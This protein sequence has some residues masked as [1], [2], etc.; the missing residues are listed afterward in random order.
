M[1]FSIHL[2][3][4][5]YFERVSAHGHIGKAAL[6]LGV[7]SGAVSK[8]ISQLEE[9][10]GVK[11]IKKKGTG[12]QITQEG[13]KLAREVS[14]PLSQIDDAVSKIM[15]NQ[16]KR[17]LSLTTVPSL[18]S[19]WLIPNLKSIEDELGHEINIVTSRKLADFSQ[20]DIDIAI[21][22][23]EGTWADCEAIKLFPSQEIC[24]VGACLYNDYQE[25]DIIDPWKEHPILMR[26]KWENW[27]L[28]ASEY[29]IKDGLRKKVILDDFLVIREALIN[30]RGFALLP[31][32]LVKD[33][34][35]SGQL[36]RVRVGEI[37]VPQSY[38]LVFSK[39]K[40]RSAKINKLIEIL[41][42]KASSNCLL[43]GG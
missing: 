2:K 39:N 19:R 4:L 8:M 15:Q 35:L 42:S 27:D 22:Y 12:I 11:L 25:G 21:R 5:H 40:S 37:D 9:R 34:I 7:T 43:G 23:G 20:G 38:Y 31:H 36:L 28:F 30:G 14:L 32:V 16:Q 1:K 33:L 17:P 6:E 10:L 18:A 26:P 13:L 29:K 24:I 41:V 3:S